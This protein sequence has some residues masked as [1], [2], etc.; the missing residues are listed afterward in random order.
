MTFSDSG[1]D[2]PTLVVPQPTRVFAPKA[3]PPSLTGLHPGHLL[4][5]GID[6][7]NNPPSLAG[8]QPPTPEELEDRFHK[9]GLAW[10]SIRKE[11]GH[12]AM[13]AVYEAYHLELDARMAVKIMRPDSAFND[14]QFRESFRDEARIM[15]NLEHPGLVRVF[16]SGF[17]VGG[18]ATDSDSTG[19]SDVFF[20]SMDL[21]VG[22]DL[23]AEFRKAPLTE[24]R[25]ID[26]FGQICAT[27]SLAHENNVI[28]RDL[29]PENI[30]L[31]ELGAV[32]VLDFGLARRDDNLL[33]K[34]HALPGAGTPEYM[35]PEQLKLGIPA[36][37]ATDVWALGVILY[38]MLT[39]Q[40]PV[41]GTW[42]V[43]SKIKNTSQSLDD[44]VRG[45]LEETPERR[46]QSAT[47]VLTKVQAIVDAPRVAAELMVQRTTNR[48][49]R[50]RLWFAVVAGGVA[51]IAGALAIQKQAAEA[52]ARLVAEQT[53]RSAE[54]L[55][56]D[57][58]GDLRERLEEVGRLDLLDS[59]TR[60]A[61]T[62][63]DHLPETVWNG[64][65]A[66]NHAW[67]LK[68][69]ADV[70][71]KLG[72]TED[73]DAAYFSHAD[74]LRQLHF[75]S[76]Q[77]TTLTREYA[78]ALGEVGKVWETR[79]DL[80]KAESIYRSQLDLL[81]TDESAQSTDTQT[82]VASASSWENLGFLHFR[83]GNM[84]QAEKAFVRQ[85]EIFREVS[86]RR[87]DDPD[88]QRNLAKSYGNLG[89]FWFYCGDY[90][91]ARAYFE[92][93]QQLFDDLSAN[94]PDDMRIFNELAIAWNKLGKAFQALEKL[95]EAAL[96]FTQFHDKINHL[97]HDVDPHHPDYQ[98]SLSTSLANLGD[99]AFLRGEFAV[100][101]GHYIEDMQITRQLASQFADDPV[102]QI[103]L[104][105]SC[106]NMAKLLERVS[107]P[108]K[109][110]QFLLEAKSIVASASAHAVGNPQLGRLQSRIEE[111]EDER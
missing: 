107:E 78:Q 5:L 37:K 35:S 33:D 106:V 1:E 72:R 15:F 10:Y 19:T 57:M 40:R 22:N 108:D 9:Q 39:D 101:R 24:E 36:S 98:R 80:T 50:N 48:R 25:A 60:S 86:S 26:I 31:P 3:L 94:V 66:R 63:F 16:D 85:L 65:S 74:I 17:L 69:Y 44:V 82:A 54:S 8:W 14:P 30:F 46:Y 42:D 29:K 105:M 52:R 2:C 61:R 99:I 100:A 92:Q 109:S 79:G 49:L 53:R 102:Y 75:D 90:S 27:V 111:L 18:A 67:T 95:E 93:Q 104:A 59:V 12:G 87:P 58:L 4:K 76:P 11:L 20:F 70:A 91:K 81:S 110:K 23:R 96:A 68:Y 34:E 55:I 84:D 7:Y 77:Q 28:H 56:E 103:D 6:S 73:A 88:I 51:V 97:A 47:E 43:P 41:A 62:Y 21:L 71:R 64:S 89:D 32:K 38:E 45:C 83:Q 13:G